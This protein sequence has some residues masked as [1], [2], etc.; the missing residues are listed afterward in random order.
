MDNKYNPD[1]IISD[2]ASRNSDMPKSTNKKVVAGK[3]DPLFKGTQV[4]AEEKRKKNIRSIFGNS[5]PDDKVNEM[6]RGLNSTDPETIKTAMMLDSYSSGVPLEQKHDLFDRLLAPQVKPYNDKINEASQD[7]DYKHFPGKKGAFDELDRAYNQ[8]KEINASVGLSDSE[9]EDWQKISNQRKN[10]A[11]NESFQKGAQKQQEIYDHQQQI[12]DI[13]KIKKDWA[14]QDEESLNRDFFLGIN[15]VRNAI[16]DGNIK[17]DFAAQMLFGGLPIGG[18][19]DVVE[20]VGMGFLTNFIS[21]AEGGASYL[22]MQDV[23]AKLHNT[24]E[25]FKAGLGND[26]KSITDQ[27]AYG[28]GDAIAMATTGNALGKLISIAGKGM[29]SSEL[30]PLMETLGEKSGVFLSGYLPTYY[31]NYLGEIAKGN[32]KEE[33][34]STA[35]LRSFITGISEL[36]MPNMKVLDGMG[37]PWVSRHISSLDN[38]LN[39]SEV[40]D[41]LSGKPITSAIVS[42]VKKQATN[43]FGEFA[44]EMFDQ[45]GQEAISAVTDAN[46]ESFRTRKNQDGE[47]D[48]LAQ[49]KNTAIVTPLITMLLGGHHTANTMYNQFKGNNEALT[50]A[51]I[52]SASDRGAYNLSLDAINKA[53]S[54]GVIT[55]EKADE[56]TNRLKVYREIIDNKTYVDD[57]TK[58][59]I[60][61]IAVNG[62]SEQLKK[63]N[64]LMFDLHVETA[65]NENIIGEDN[66]GALSASE[67]LRQNAISISNQI[68]KAGKLNTVKSVFFGGEMEQ[69][70]EAKKNLNVNSGVKT[71][72]ENLDL[73][74]ETHQDV[75]T[76][77]GT[78]AR[79]ATIQEKKT[80]IDEQIK[81][82]SDLI[83]GFDQAI[84]ATQSD[85]QKAPLEQTK[86]SLVQKNNDLL[87]QKQGL[88]QEEA[89][90]NEK[91]PELEKQAKEAIENDEKKAAEAKTKDSN[92]STESNQNT[93]DKSSDS[94]SVPLTVEKKDNLVSNVEKEFDVE[95]NANVDG[96][97]EP[98]KIN[99]KDG[100]TP[101]ATEMRKSAAEQKL[102]D[103]GLKIKTQL[104]G[105]VK[106]SQTSVK[107]PSNENTSV[108]QG[109]NKNIASNGDT[110]S[111]ENNPNS[112][113]EEQGQK[114]Q[115]Q[116]VLTES[117]TEKKEDGTEKSVP[118]LPVSKTNV[119]KQQKQNRS[120]IIR[121]V[122]K[123]NPLANK[124]EV[125]EKV[126]Q[127]MLRQD[128]NSDLKDLNQTKGKMLKSMVDKE[129]N[130]EFSKSNKLASRKKGKLANTRKKSQKERQKENDTNQKLADL[131]GKLI[132]EEQAKKEKENAVNMEGLMKIF[133]VIDDFVK[134]DPIYYAEPKDGILG[135]KGVQLRHSLNTMVIN[136]MP[137]VQRA[138]AVTNKDAST[139]T[140]EQKKFEAGKLK[141]QIFERLQ[142]EIKDV[143]AISLPNGM[144]IV[145]LKGADPN[146]SEYIANSINN[147]VVKT[148]DELS[149][150]NEKNDKYLWEFYNEAEE[151]GKAE[152]LSPKFISQSQA[153]LNELAKGETS[154]EQIDL[155]ID[156]ALQEGNTG[157]RGIIPNNDKTPESNLAS[158]FYNAIEKIMRDKHGISSSPNI[159]RVVGI[160]F[161]SFQNPFQAIAFAQQVASGKLRGFDSISKAIYKETGELML[162]YIDQYSRK[163]GS[164]M[165]QIFFLSNDMT[166]IFNNAPVT[167]MMAEIT[168]S[169]G[170]VY[171]MNIGKSAT[172][173]MN[174]ITNALYYAKRAIRENGALNSVYEKLWQEAKDD[175]LNSFDKIL[176]IAEMFASQNAEN[177]PEL[178]LLQDMFSIETIKKMSDNVV[179]EENMATMFNQFLVD[180][181]APV[182]QNLEDPKFALFQLFSSIYN[183]QRVDAG[184]NKPG[185]KIYNQQKGRTEQTFARPN[186]ISVWLNKLNIV[187]QKLGNVEDKVFFQEFLNATSGSS[188]SKFDNKANQYNP[189]FAFQDLMAKLREVEFHSFKN[190]TEGQGS[191]SVRKLENATDNQIRLTSILSFWNS[192][193]FN[194]MSFSNL[195]FPSNKPK[196]KSYQVGRFVRVDGVYK[197]NDQTI[198]GE[199]EFPG[200]FENFINTIIG[201]S[202]L[203]SSELQKWLPTY[204]EVG[205]DKLI[206]LNKNK[207]AI[208]AQKSF[209]NYVIAR[210]SSAINISQP[211]V[212]GNGTSILKINNSLNTVIERLT[213]NPENIK[214]EA[215]KIL[216]EISLGNE[217]Y[218]ADLPKETRQ[219]LKDITKDA[220]LSEGILFFEDYLVNYDVNQQFIFN[221]FVAPINVLAESGET[222]R[223]FLYNRISTIIAPGDLLNL[224]RDINYGIVDIEFEDESFEMVDGKKK[225]VINYKDAEG[226]TQKLVLGSDFDTLEGTE[227]ITPQFSIEAS[228]AVGVRAGYMGNL[229][230]ATS[231][232]NNQG[233]MAMHK[234]MSVV[235]TPELRASS[236]LMEAIYQ[237]MIENGLDKIET[238]GATKSK[239]EQKDIT[240]IKVSKG[241]QN[242]EFSQKVAVKTLSH[243]SVV[244]Q[245]PVNLT[246][247][248]ESGAVRHNKLPV[249][250]MDQLPIVM[251]TQADHVANSASDALE[252]NQ[253]IGTKYISKFTNLISK[254]NKL[255]FVYDG[256]ID[257]AV[258]QQNKEVAEKRQAV[259]NQLIGLFEEYSSNM[260]ERLGKQ[261]SAKISKILS[262][263]K[264]NTDPSNPSYS[265]EVDIEGLYEMFNDVVRDTQQ[266]WVKGGW[267]SIVSEKVA[268]RKLAYQGE[269]GVFEGE[270][271]IS[272]EM[273]DQLGWSNGQEVLI[274]KL[275]FSNMATK[276][277]AK[278]VVGPISGSSIGMPSEWIVINGSD[279]DAD[280]LSSM[281]IKTNYRQ[282]YIGKLEKIDSNLLGMSLNDALEMLSGDEGKLNAYL[283]ARSQYFTQDVMNT[284][285]NKQV[286]DPAVN[287][288]S[289]Q[290]VSVDEWNKAADE[291]GF[292]IEEENIFNPDAQAN[293]AQ[294]I[295]GSDT[296]MGIVAATDSTLLRMAATETTMNSAENITIEN[297]G[298]THLVGATTVDTKGGKSV[299]PD[300]TSIIDAMANFLQIMVDSFK[301]NY[302]TRFGINDNNLLVSLFLSQSGIPARKIMVVMNQPIAKLYAAMQKQSQDPNKPSNIKN[303][304]EIFNLRATLAEIIMNK[305]DS[306]FYSNL[307]SKLGYK[308]E[309]GTFTGLNA[310]AYNV[311]LDRVN[312]RYQNKLGQQVS[313]SNKSENVSDLL[314]QF[315]NMSDEMLEAQVE[316]YQLLAGTRNMVKSMSSYTKIRKRFQE[317]YTNPYDI[318]TF[319][320]DLVD[321]GIMAPIGVN[322]VKATTFNHIQITDQ[323]KINQLRN[324]SNQLKTIRLN[325]DTMF[326]LT[327]EDKKIIKNYLNQGFTKE[328][329][330]EFLLYKERMI[331][332]A[333]VDGK[334]VNT[335]YIADAVFRTQVDGF[336]KGVAL[337]TSILPM[338]KQLNQAKNQAEIDEVADKSKTPTLV[339]RM[340]NAANLKIVSNFLFSEISNVTD[341]IERSEKINSYNQ[342][343]GGMLDKFYK[344]KSHFA[345]NAFFQYLENQNIGE[346]APVGNRRGNKIYSNTFHFYKNAN[347]SPIDKSKVKDI[348]SI[349][350]DIEKQ[351]GLSN[352]IEQIFEGTNENVQTNEQKEQEF[353]N[354]ISNIEPSRVA[355]LG[356]NKDSFDFLMGLR[357]AQK[358]N[359]GTS[360]DLVV[361]ENKIF[362]AVSG[363]FIGANEKSKKLYNTEDLK[364]V[365]EEDFVDTENPFNYIT[366]E[367][368]SA[369]R[370][371]TQS[372]LNDVRGFDLAQNYIASIHKSMEV[373]GQAAYT[374]MYQKSKDSRVL[375]GIDR[376][377]DIINH[378]EIK[379]SLQTLSEDLY[380]MISVLNEDGN[381]E[382]KT[383]YELIDP[384]I[385]TDSQTDPDLMEIINEIY[386]GNF[387]EVYAMYYAMN[388]NSF[389]Q[390]NNIKPILSAATNQKLL[391][392]QQES[393]NSSEADMSALETFLNNPKDTDKISWDDIQDL[394][395]ENHT[396]YQKGFYHTIDPDGNLIL[397]KKVL[398]STEGYKM[399]SGRGITVKQIKR[400]SI[401]LFFPIGYYTTDHENNYV[402]T[403]A[404][405][406]DPI[407]VLQR[408][409]LSQATP[410]KIF[411]MIS[412]II[413]ANQ[414][415]DMPEGFD[416]VELQLKLQEVLKRTKTPSVDEIMY[417]LGSK[418]ELTEGLQNYLGVLNVRSVMNNIA[419]IIDFLNPITQVDKKGNFAFPQTK[420]FQ[421]SIFGSE[422]SHM[423]MKNPISNQDIKSS[424]RV[425]GNTM[426]SK[427]KLF[428]SK[429]PIMRTNNAN[430]IGHGGSTISAFLTNKNG[431]LPTTFREAINA[432]ASAV[433]FNFAYS[434]LSQ[435]ITNKVGNAKVKFVSQEAYNQMEIEMG[436]NAGDTNMMYDEDT[437]EIIINQEMTMDFEQHP[438]ALLH[439]AIHAMTAEFY[440]TNKEFK[441]DLDSIVQ[442]F[443]TAFKANSPAFQQL[444]Q[445]N[446]DLYKQIKEAIIEQDGE[447]SS[448]E[449][450]AYALTSNGADF[451]QLLNNLESK[452]LV[453]ANMKQSLWS[454]FITSLSRMFG[455]PVND[456]SLLRDLGNLMDN[457]YEN[458][459][460]TAQSSVRE[461]ASGI[462]LINNEAFITPDFLAE[463]YLINQGVD[464]HGQVAQHF[465]NITGQEP[466]EIDYIEA[467][468]QEI[469]IQAV[470]RL[471]YLAKQDPKQNVFLQAFLATTGQRTKDFAAAF[472]KIVNRNDYESAGDVHASS[473]YKVAGYLDG[474]YYKQADNPNKPDEL[475]MDVVY[476]TNTANY[477]EATNRAIDSQERIGNLFSKNDIAQRVPT[478]AILQ[479]AIMGYIKESQGETVTSIRVISVDEMGGVTETLIDY[480][481][482]RGYAQDVMNNYNSSINGV[483]ERFQNINN[484][485][486]N[487]INASSKGSVIANED[488]SIA[489]AVEKKHLTSDEAIKELLKR[490]KAQ[491]FAFTGMH[492]FQKS[493]LFK[494][495]RETILT[496][497]DGSYRNYTE[498]QL[499]LF[500]ARAKEL[501]DP[502]KKLGSQILSNSVFH[503]I[504]HE[505]MSIH[506]GQEVKSIVA[507]MNQLEG[508][509]KQIVDIDSGGSRSFMSVLV[510]FFQSKMHNKQIMDMV[511]Q[512]QKIADNLLSKANTDRREAA[513]LWK[514]VQKENGISVKDKRRMK[515]TDEV[516]LMFKFAVPG[517]NGSLVF[518]TES[519]FANETHTPAE[520][521]YYLFVK[522]Q[523]DTLM[524]SMFLHN[525]MGG[526]ALMQDSELYNYWEMDQQEGQY[527]LKTTPIPASGF[528]Y[529]QIIS[530]FLGETGTDPRAD[531]NWKRYQAQLQVAAN[532]GK[533]V[534]YENPITKKVEI[535]TMQEWAN[536][537]SDNAYAGVYEQI[538][539]KGLSEKGAGNIKNWKNL[540]GRMDM[541]SF[542]VGKD[543]HTLEHG[544]SYDLNH[545]FNTF[546]DEVYALKIAQTASVYKE[547]IDF[548][549][550]ET[551]EKTGKSDMRK[552]VQDNFDA[553][554]LNQK[555]ARKD[556]KDLAKRKI[557]SVAEKLAVMKALGWNMGAQFIDAF[558]VVPLILH[559]GNILNSIK[560]IKIGMNLLTKNTE[561]QNQ[562]L[563]SA[564][565][566]MK[567]MNTI[568]D[569]FSL[570]NSQPFK[571]VFKNGYMEA[572]SKVNSSMYFLYKFNDYIKFMSIV[573]EEVGASKF[574]SMLAK[575]S[576]G[577]RLSE[578]EYKIINNATDKYIAIQGGLTKSTSIRQT[579]SYVRSISHFKSWVLPGFTRNWGRM[580]VT[581]GEYKSMPIYSINFW[582]AVKKFD[583]NQRLLKG[584]RLDELNGYS[585]LEMQQALRGMRNNIIAAAVIG[586]AFYLKYANGDDDDLS[587][588]IKGVVQNDD[589]QGKL[590]IGLIV[591]CIVGAN[592]LVLFG[593]AYLVNVLGDLVDV[594]TGHTTEK[595][596][597][598]ST[599]GKGLDK[600]TP[601]GNLAELGNEILYGLSRVVNK[602][603]A[604]FNYGENPFY[605]EDYA[606]KMYDW[607]E[608]HSW[609]NAVH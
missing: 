4:D 276:F 298:K 519:Q 166:R 312:S 134:E 304:A 415:K 486:P 168:S 432:M 118:S 488:A 333:N 10:L 69:A 347:L 213:K 380:K 358:M 487:Q 444:Q 461:M 179:Y 220:I 473:D 468:K 308:V 131:Y 239:S 301:H 279:F 150:I 219:F 503:H 155:A 49:V 377:V 339:Y 478:K 338:N 568:R 344:Y 169:G 154:D 283:N 222:P 173:I 570:T 105:F 545:N 483:V 514:Q 595:T 454:R 147:F 16:K 408:I 83:K 254:L 565:N 573:G 390:W 420:L 9:Y 393:I 262:R 74:P 309:D 355:A 600:L 156:E 562:K 242:I 223:G 187:A 274:A 193:R 453:P 423:D 585:D 37:N 119:S 376:Q 266:L 161:N 491:I 319:I 417:L 341:I 371:L 593:G 180:L 102:A 77:E 462:M 397:F 382:Q 498:D 3:N 477:E 443:I 195:F 329:L 499:A 349:I 78:K 225:Y 551:L 552:W 398:V 22:G 410:N 481:K 437:K 529:N 24:K 185:T 391:T 71:E 343:I 353:K 331:D 421:S 48:F 235:L 603:E 480:S 359:S 280:G 575:M 124:E 419:T 7:E 35:N 295:K 264:T 252:A 82:N 52:G 553:K 240:K 293:R 171:S 138:F 361:H 130:N 136:L 389:K 459:G 284:F 538:N 557:L 578:A 506:A 438:E 209:K 93:G 337:S 505:Y 554:F 297:N 158:A 442:E 546:L 511:R 414:S 198:V 100:E 405:K 108:N 271:M 121:N 54:K 572:A 194:N 439:E 485:L 1:N 564:L 19:S 536:I 547:A 400:P 218:V 360:I 450:I 103:A 544:V 250:L 246:M 114:G 449:F 599:L 189:Y 190:S 288:M 320:R 522:G 540:I 149:Q 260:K 294:E 370:F 73:D 21:T 160:M 257:E 517:P 238:K 458:M 231:G 144:T 176:E 99:K 426:S 520:I 597:Y 115:R 120:E 186:L 146:S 476:A 61:N 556:P 395:I 531:E 2:V 336:F 249:Q 594:A 39:S 381:L 210:A 248:D 497:L 86:Q 579:D 471:V 96:T 401:G 256:G 79:I 566:A 526:N 472:Q 413:K 590:M 451:F 402:L 574:E 177:N 550:S 204:F 174:Q 558:D 591:A 265:F 6:V 500:V 205:A 94:K 433:N 289:I 299:N 208:A 508:T 12:N 221:S 183:T 484:T 351:L 559:S 441:K 542:T 502:D 32:S 268:G 255:S 165:S 68:A 332:A 139:L 524:K 199:G 418:S 342:I 97:Y 385:N 229:K 290:T 465:Q 305:G 516:N 379:N 302:M 475:I 598:S 404:S 181:F 200:M 607:K 307:L 151:T 15:N 207:L 601:V 241:G 111:N 323:E 36:I 352:D 212:L 11:N 518:K 507:K 70:K 81:T 245:Q 31:D 372:G 580:G 567:N 62:N 563:F 356:L 328:T 470:K 8:Y 366:Q 234:N 446:P 275:P 128:P 469:E 335:F 530:H 29:A 456:R 369:L 80:S 386:N 224:N 5:V 258:T 510:P 396:K 322:K 67:S 282:E 269:N 143:L 261:A 394:T 47:N 399:E 501:T 272:Q 41:L 278:I 192:Y 403:N 482:I 460:V 532:G 227:F 364:K 285:R 523:M 541:R 512:V 57:N 182:E 412:G 463:D 434:S 549:V 243:E 604:R 109:E 64:G 214:R 608:E 317:G 316:V 424:F 88:I 101:E 365:E 43:V 104:G 28:L 383:L 313:V 436:L 596:K 609:Y 378:E 58:K 606:E 253:I 162:N 129:I 277:F 237:H 140:P 85:E 605:N 406:V 170:R 232:M 203:S 197:Y 125:Y 107:Q 582:R 172:D 50:A 175:P 303:N 142:K 90:H 464:F 496:L 392:I 409:D 152:M 539:K 296:G 340:M 429:S 56:I 431:Q 493:Q 474:L 95:V 521:A 440:D 325:M 416:I 367:S 311:K 89:K 51:I 167:N 489:E 592:P 448:K 387:A 113:S 135:E 467:K 216:K 178:G 84:E 318:P 348:D 602:D 466:K 20:K 228:I 87:L 63:I 281:E 513:K 528:R 560:G 571:Q 247:Q 196:I 206:R 525:K 509:N 92:K 587:K 577:E 346:S 504:V 495:Y 33:A 132:E 66:T 455:F 267:S 122:V 345:N 72:V 589:L 310:T 425:E 157:V 584:T 27:V 263:L 314:E 126:K 98:L 334:W 452:G 26:P 357:F 251:G 411:G 226:N 363:Y 217:R 75:K 576:N 581:V 583:K 479:A 354:L 117:Q 106:P 292:K 287:A 163:D 326:G 300:G 588:A 561:A 230:T 215:E 201:G 368:V 457:Y 53:K 273:A 59:A 153:I 259:I 447:V 44:E 112:Q 543:I 145:D 30:V 537:L 315:N 65:P 137:F 123:E 492:E 184:Q 25:N 18:M 533:L 42:Q 527:I 23:A 490:K 188:L 548:T 586:A 534:S 330:K 306:P 270:A 350:E 374:P 286:S 430:T 13:Y 233:E 569:M 191:N 384:S 555:E 321:M 127:E 445:S 494:M 291:L 76:F 17:S 211:Q 148:A 327:E 202:K 535:H 116:D 375:L 388:T 60:A 34:E 427:K 14:S 515:H 373:R 38:L 244:V 428:N 407:S 324:E 133:S 435:F 55:E 164:S 362:D 45:F 40:A 46:Y 141:A 110:Q 422:I 159:Q 236:P 91:L